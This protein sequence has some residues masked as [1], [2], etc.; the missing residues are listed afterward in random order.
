MIQ[1]EQVRRGQLAAATDSG[2]IQCGSA[3]KAASVGLEGSQ[4]EQETPATK[5]ERKKDYSG[6]KSHG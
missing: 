3:P 4:T 1:H 2:D 5:A 6:E